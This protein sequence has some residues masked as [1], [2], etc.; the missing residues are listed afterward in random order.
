MR[1]VAWSL[2]VGGFLLL[3]GS[4]LYA[5]HAPAIGP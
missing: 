2:V 3:P 4:W 5:G 1:R